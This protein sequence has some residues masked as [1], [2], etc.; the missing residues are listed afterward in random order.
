MSYEYWSRLQPDLLERHVLARRL[1][2]GL[3]HHAVRA[4]ADRL[5]DLLVLRAAERGGGAR[6]RAGGGGKGGHGSGGE[7][8][9]A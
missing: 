5:L 8:G 9:R 7:V 2:L 1:V 6:G 3:V 4:L